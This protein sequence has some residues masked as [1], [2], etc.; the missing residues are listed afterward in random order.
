MN[1]L[2]NMPK[3]RRIRTTTYNVPL[4]A[5]L[6]WGKDHQ[7]RQLEHVLVGVELSDGAFGIAEATPR[8]SIYGE[9]QASIA[10]MVEGHLTPLLLGQD[11]DSVDAIA[12]LSVRLAHIKNNNTAKG[13]LDMA[14]HQALANSRGERLGSYLGVSRQ[15]IR[16]S[17]I[18]STGVPEAVIADVGSAFGAG[19]R[20][21]KVKIGSDIPREIDTIARLLDGYP[22]AQF[23]VDA[24]ETLDSANAAGVLG[25]L[26]EMGVIH[27]EEALPAHRLRDR[28]QLR[29]GCKMPIIADDSAFTLRDLEREIEF[30]TFD[31]L[32]IKTARTGFSE[33]RRM[34]ELCSA[35]GKDVMVGSQAGSLLGCLHAAVFAGHDAVNCASEC[36]F[37]TKTEADLSWAPPIKDGYVQ[38]EAVETALA[39]MQATLAQLF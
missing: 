33:S 11:I 39:R 36:S 21:F 27:C 30:D 14:L 34:L 3:I 29:R 6:T 4:K 37:F 25:R 28:R 20:V 8:P 26:Y 35:A 1:N 22:A 18:V 9:T 24:N 38:L 5:T 10:H 23:Y 12:A 32:N 13:A 15:R 31:I 16:L 2:K 17:T 7:L 19:I